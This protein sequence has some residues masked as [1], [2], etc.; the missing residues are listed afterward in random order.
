[1]LSEIS[2]EEY[3]TKFNKY[4][5]TKYSVYVNRSTYYQF[6]TTSKSE[7]ECIKILK[8]ITDNLIY[9]QKITYEVYASRNGEKRTLYKGRTK[10]YADI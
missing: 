7:E 9:G 6:V 2:H 8:E 5:K 10:C 1:M 3:L 4:P